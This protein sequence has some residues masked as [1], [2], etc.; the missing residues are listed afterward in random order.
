M[1]RLLHLVLLILFVSLTA[2]ARTAEVKRSVILRPT[3]SIVNE[4]ISTLKP[5]ATLDLLEPDATDGYFHVT[6]PGG[7]EG[8]VWSKNIRIITGGVSPGGGAGHAG[9]PQLYPDPI[10]TPGLAD[11]LAVSDLTKRYTDGCPSGKTSCT[12]SQAHRNVPSSMH[13]QVYDEYNVPQGERNIK[14]G[15][16]DHFYPLCAGGSNNIKRRCGSIRSCTPPRAR[17][18]AKA[19]GPLMQT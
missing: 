17:T 15:E 9:P 10:K 7:Q 4:P 2:G 1:K 16:V 3:P 14:H 13:N 12:Y 11:T 18:P 5:P 8:W 19:S 6:A